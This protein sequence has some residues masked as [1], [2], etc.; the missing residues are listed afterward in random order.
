MDMVKLLLVT[1]LPAVALGCLVGILIG[2]YRV[3]KQAGRIRSILNTR[4]RILYSV[5]IL[6]GIGC[7]LFGILY[8]PEQDM[9]MD[10]DFYDPGMDMMEPGMEEPAGEVGLL[11]L[12][13]QE[14]LLDQEALPEEPIDY[15]EPAADDEG[16]SVQTAEEEAPQPAETQPQIAIVKDAVA[17]ARPKR[18]AKVSGS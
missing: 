4:Q 1:L 13:Q 7:I 11:D 10:S 3:K 16:D 8:T 9:G 6:V 17:T 2:K 5:S 14:M 15:E 18:E 12:P